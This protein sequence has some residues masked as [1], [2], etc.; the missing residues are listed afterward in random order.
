MKMSSKNENF[1]S[2]SKA[3]HAFSNINQNYNKIIQKAKPQINEGPHHKRARSDFPVNFAK[4]LELQID[5]P[6]CTQLDKSND[7]VNSK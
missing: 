4:N 6:K 3:N 7:V 1:K 2:T 5:Y